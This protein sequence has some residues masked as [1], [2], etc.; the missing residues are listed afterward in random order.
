[1]IVNAEKGGFAS[2]NLQP[3]SSVMAT[4]LQ[5]MKCPGN[6]TL[7]TSKYTIPRVGKI[8]VQLLGRI[9]DSRA[10]TYRQDIRA[11]NIQSYTKN[12]LPT[13]QTVVISTPNGLMDHEEAIRQNV[14][15]QV[16]GYFY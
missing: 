9:N 8:T 13:H 4:F 11:Q 7:K 3:I 12:K 10:L 14:G 1:M 16:L 6:A 5:T 2:A 15:G